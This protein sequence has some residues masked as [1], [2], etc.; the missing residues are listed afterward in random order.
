MKL[1]GIEKI[2]SSKLQGSIYDA[3]PKKARIFR[4]KYDIFALFD[5]PQ[6]GSSMI[7]ELTA[8]H[9]SGQLL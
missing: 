5:P 7:P 6:M 9:T 3:K 4:R 1:G 2:H 8:S